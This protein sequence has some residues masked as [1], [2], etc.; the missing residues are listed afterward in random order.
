MSAL[1]RNIVAVV[2]KQVTKAEADLPAPRGV[3]LL[4]QIRIGHSQ[5]CELRLP[6]G[7]WRAP[8][9]VET[10]VRFAWFA[11]SC[12]PMTIAATGESIVYVEA[13]V[14]GSGHPASGGKHSQ[15]LL[16]CKVLPAVVQKL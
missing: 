16:G 13:A 1:Q 8:E 5:A 10:Q 12:Q 9:R 2:E 3:Q 14:L 7:P 11:S 4:V 6:A 15:E